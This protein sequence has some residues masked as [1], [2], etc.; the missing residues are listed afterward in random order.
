MCFY[1][2]E[3][4]LILCRGYYWWAKRS[5]HK[6]SHEKFSGVRLEKSLEGA[7]LKIL[8]VLAWKFKIILFMGI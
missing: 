4:N 6:R 2:N 8:I 3:R 1:L 7:K 5:T